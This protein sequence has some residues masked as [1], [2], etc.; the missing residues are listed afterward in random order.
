MDMDLD[1]DIDKDMYMDMDIGTD[2]DKETERNFSALSYDWSN[3]N[4]LMNIRE[5]MNPTCSQA[6]AGIFE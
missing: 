1:I 6:L 2:I 3:S 4:S 5:H